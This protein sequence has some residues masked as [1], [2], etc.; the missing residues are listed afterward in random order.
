MCH[1]VQRDMWTCECMC[2]YH[3]LYRSPLS[4]FLHTA[5]FLSLFS[6]CFLSNLIPPFF[7]LS[8]KRHKDICNRFHVQRHSRSSIPMHRHLISLLP[9]RPKSLHRHYSDSIRLWKQVQHK[10]HHHS[11]NSSRHLQPVQ[12]FYINSSSNNKSKDFNTFILDL[13]FMWLIHHLVYKTLSL[14][15]HLVNYETRFSPGDSSAD[16]C[17]YGRMRK[18]GEWCI[19]IIIVYQYQAPAPLDVFILLASVLPTSIM[20]WKSWRNQRWF[21]WNRWVSLELYENKGRWGERIMMKTWRLRQC[22]CVMMMIMWCGA[23]VVS[24][25]KSPCYCIR[26]STFYGKSKS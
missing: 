5:F 8:C 1:L 17:L 3:P 16:M 22:V 7:V 18:R 14:W 24:L 23:H 2:V 15:I 26:L 9:W 4:L 6:S 19:L 25:A 21:D 11:N 13:Q 10:E 20:P 12:H